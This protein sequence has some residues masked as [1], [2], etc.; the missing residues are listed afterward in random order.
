[1]KFSL[2][3]QTIALLVFFTLGFNA[4]A[5]QIELKRKLLRS[6]NLSM[7]YTN[8]ENG[9]LNYQI[10]AGSPPK[11]WGENKKYF[12]VLNSSYTHT[13]LSPTT[14]PD[15]V[16]FN[17]F[18]LTPI[19]RQRLNDKWSFS[20]V[21][22]FSF[23]QEEGSGFFNSRGLALVGVANWT[24]NLSPSGTNY[25]L[26]IVMIKLA[27]R[28]LVVPNFSY[29][30]VSQDFNWAFRF[31]FPR[32][33]LEKIYSRYII[34]GFASINF[35]TFLL[36]QDGP[37]TSAPNTTYLNSEKTLLGLRLH[38]K[39][40]QN[41]F[42]DVE[43][44]LI[45]NERLFLSDDSRDRVLGTDFSRKGFETYFTNFILGYKF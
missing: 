27:Q 35:D 11:F 44:G 32:I 41:L 33:S 17:K 42:I 1:M 28:F 39:G 45:L 22:P 40:F 31:G 3:F 19:F 14:T 36:N 25:G 20:T 8:Y 13:Q 24:K 29:S 23:A 16:D 2:R 30:Y 34:G 12:F 10:N 7:Q 6:P 21:L 15:R 38:F 37:L 26:G 4:K 5:Q 43:T 9:L 18:S